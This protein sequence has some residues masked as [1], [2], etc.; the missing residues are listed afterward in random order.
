MGRRK[1]N[2]DNMSAGFPQGAFDQWDKVLEP[3]ETRKDFLRKAA[4]N[5]LARRKK[6]KPKRPDDQQK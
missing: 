5:E 4:D 1:K 3:G 6:R 2:F